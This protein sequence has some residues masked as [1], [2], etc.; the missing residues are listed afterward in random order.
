MRRFVVSVQSPS[1]AGSND[2]AAVPWGAAS[3]AAPRPGWAPTGGATPDDRTRRL[4][5]DAIR[6][7]VLD[8]GQAPAPDRFRV[9]ASVYQPL[10][11]PFQ[12][13]MAQG[14]SLRREVAIR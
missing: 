9:P 13:R 1:R 11:P 8:F 2:G 6:R 10:E 14:P 7:T 5:T 4:G 3:P 12:V